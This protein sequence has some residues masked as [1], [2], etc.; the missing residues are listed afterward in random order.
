MRRAEIASSLAAF[1]P[2]VWGLKVPLRVPLKG[3]IR[4]PLRIPI[5]DQEGF[6]I[7][8]LGFEGFRIW[9]LGLKDLVV[10]GLGFGVWGL[11]G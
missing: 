2:T 3:S 8:D 10:W 1:S 5:R 4:V 11:K 6:R 9:G 7:W